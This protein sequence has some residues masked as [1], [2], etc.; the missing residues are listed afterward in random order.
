VTA[1]RLGIADL[2]H[3]WLV[4]LC[5]IL[6]LA[7]VLAPLLVLYGL[8]LGVVTGMLAC[9]KDDP[10]N[11]EVRIVGN[12]ALGP[13][14]IEAV[15]ARPEVAFLVPMT[16]SIAR[17]LYFRLDRP[18]S[19]LVEARLLPTAAGD[20]LLPPGRPALAQDEVAITPQ[21]ARR[22]GVEPGARLL[23]GN[24]R[25][26]EDGRRQRLELPFTVAAILPEGRLGGAAALVDPAPLERLE[27]FLDGWALP[28][29][30]FP[31]GQPLAERP[32]L[33]ENLRLYARSLED[34]APLVGFL[35]A[36]PR[37]LDVRSEAAQIQGILDLDAN[38]VRVFGL[39]VLV[40]GGGY[41]VSL[42]ASLWGNVVRKRRE[43]GIIRLLGASNLALVAFPLAQAVVVAGLGGITALLLYG[44]VAGVINAR[45]GGAL[46]SALPVCTLP[47]AQATLALGATLVAASLAALAGGLQATRVEPTE[48]MRDG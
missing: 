43:L 1:V 41:L 36:P 20:P 22:L 31:E 15:R 44:L 5:Q 47:P 7:A 13:S 27:A 48:G 32:Q 9:L 30:G 18:G 4:A 26:L 37:R 25:V 16:R 34:V 6:A 24:V 46:C 3:E 23:G 42:A 33:F 28:D 2:R 19:G 21:L 8:K 29:A 11:R 38:L 14:D 17:T 35:E 45:F 39:I 40:G 12:L 10:A